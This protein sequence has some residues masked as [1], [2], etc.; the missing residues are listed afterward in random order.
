MDSE[1]L[2]DRITARQVQLERLKAAVGKEYVKTVL[3]YVNELAK[4]IAGREDELSEG[5]QKAVKE[6]QS[7]VRR[8]MGEAIDEA[9]TQFTKTAEGLAPESQRNAKQD[10]VRGAGGFIKNSA[11]ATLKNEQLVRQ[12]MNKP[13]QATGQ[14]FPEMLAE[15][16]ASETRKMNR[17]ITRGIVS[18]QS[19]R[20]I[21]QAI[22]GTV[23]LN[24]RDG[25][26]AKLE[27]AAQTMTSTA[28][29]HV[30][31]TSKL[32][33]YRNNKDILSGYEFNA[34]LDRKTSSVCKGLDGEV[35]PLEKKGTPQPPIH[36]N[37]R[38]TL[39]PIVKGLEDT[40]DT[41]A[42][43]TGATKAKDYFTWLKRQPKKVQFDALG[44]ERAEIF[45]SKNMTA[46]KFKQLSYNRNF[47]P[48]TLD[49]MKKKAGKLGYDLPE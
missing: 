33:L 14:L 44:K 36:P 37:C 23:S 11:I 25:Q 15:F 19:N 5:T 42:S 4:E 20:E 40:D 45:R 16:K 2:Q 26:A 29:Q 12:V 17:V 18:G 10:V 8:Q 28:I 13:I 47:E 30:D 34:V 39:L 43:E 6:L 38:S 27:R 31:S 32:A 7:D 49:E 41:R 21:A 48:L 3:P 9:N 46:K 1:S 24:R 35:F 22:R